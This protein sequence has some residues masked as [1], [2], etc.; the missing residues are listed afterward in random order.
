MMMFQ[1]SMLAPAKHHQNH[2]RTSK[3]FGSTRKHT[4]MEV[5]AYHQFS[6][7]NQEYKVSRSLQ[8]DKHFFL[9]IWLNRQNGNII[10]HDS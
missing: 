4:I 2:H 9:F 6:M 8:I 1:I 5:Q 3:L 7:R 10:I